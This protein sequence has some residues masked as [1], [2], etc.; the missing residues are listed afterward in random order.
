MF[1]APMLILGLS[2]CKRPE[3]QS[4]KTDPAQKIVATITPL[5]RSLANLEYAYGDGM[6]L[7]ESKSIASGIF[8]G[9]MKNVYKSP[10]PVFD[11]VV[12]KD[13]AVYRKTMI[14]P[15]SAVDAIGYG[16]YFIFLFTVLY[17]AAFDVKLDPNSI[18]QELKVMGNEF[19]TECSRVCAEPGMYYQIYNGYAFG[20]I[21]EGN[22]TLK[23][24]VVSEEVY[25]VEKL[26]R[27]QGKSATS[28]VNKNI[29]TQDAAD[30][31]G[32]ELRKLSINK[33]DKEVWSL[34]FSEAV[35]LLKLKGAGVKE[36]RELNF[37]TR[38]NSQYAITLVYVNESSW[39]MLNCP[40]KISAIKQLGNYCKKFTY[41]I[42]DQDVYSEGGQNMFGT[43]SPDNRILIMGRDNC[44]TYG[45][46]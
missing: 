46:K 34:Q 30:R 10:E 43:W 7:T 27:I 38:I 2:C 1:L 9:Y 12:A 6:R 13:G 37:V 32:A 16:P 40:Q 22:K 39:N 14:S 3:Q 21:N 5:K 17:P 19:N 36:I 20:C 25:K 31:Y 45:E 26:E 28:R 11:V 44:G 42:N 15:K 29:S 33:T 41:I 35:P 8:A 18:P 4:Q 24:D 23:F